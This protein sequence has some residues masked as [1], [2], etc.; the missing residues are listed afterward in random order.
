MIPIVEGEGTVLHV[1]LAYPGQ[2]INY[3]DNLRLINML[4]SESRSAPKIV[5]FV[6]IFFC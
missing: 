5:T 1:N 4:L 2:F 3:P 6:N